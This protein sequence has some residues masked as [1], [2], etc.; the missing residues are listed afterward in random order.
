M[1]IKAL[2]ILAI[3]AAAAYYAIA[4]KKINPFS[5]KIEDDVPFRK[6]D[7]EVTSLKELQGENGTLFVLLS[8]WCPHCLTQLVNIYPISE[9]LENEKVNIVAIVSGPD[10]DTIHNWAAQHQ[11]PWS[12]KRVYWH[13]GLTEQLKIKKNSTPYIILRNRN[14]EI[15]HNEPGVHSLQQM[16]DI[17]ADM[18]ETYDDY[19]E[20][21]K[22]PVHPL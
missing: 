3:V 17:I 8:T 13:D 16:M 5:N 6:F 2:L 10:N 9:G 7:G 18:F 11:I 12:W 22:E 4:V 19:K 14:K 20:K 1:N 21:F 15:V